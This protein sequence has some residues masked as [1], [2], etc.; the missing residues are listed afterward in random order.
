M[1]VHHLNCAS[2]C[3]RG[4]RIL[5]GDGGLLAGHE[6][7]CHCLL[8]ETADE[9]VLIDSGLG[10]A[11]CANPKR[12]GQPMRGAFRPKCDPAE[13]AV[14]RV[15]DLGLDPADVRKII[16]THLDVDHAGGIGDFPEAEVHVFAPE[17]KAAL[18]PPLTEKLRYIPEQWGH[19]PQWV[20]HEV[21]GDSWFGFE[22]IKALDGDEIAL[23]PLVGHSRGHTGVAVNTSRG[24]LL[25]CGDAYFDRH[26]VETP[27]SCAPGFAFFQN[28]VGSDNKVRKRNEARLR[29]LALGHSG[30]VRLVC[31]HDAVE[32]ERERSAAA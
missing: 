29:E 26:Q 22:S 8:I 16:C 28:V 21:E 20:G 9:L 31:S 13:S 24:W 12:L 2:M 10:T 3:P 11:D 27:H 1:K 14:N 6:I 25:H 4:S 32:F 19:G 23:V 5:G 18:N 7:V 15:R 17:L 30:E